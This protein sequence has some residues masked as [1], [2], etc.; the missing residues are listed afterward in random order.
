[1]R[2][3]Q[4]EQEVQRNCCQKSKRQLKFLRHILRKE[5]LENKV[6]NHEEVLKIYLT[7]VD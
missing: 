5:G 1:M 4:G 7:S 3:L 2:K 6:D